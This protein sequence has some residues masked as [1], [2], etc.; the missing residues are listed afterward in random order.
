MSFSNNAIGFYLQVEDSLSPSLVKAEKNYGKF[1]KKLD[2]WNTKAFQS[3]S[4]GFAGVAKAV[5]GGTKGASVG[6]RGGMKIVVDFNKTST[7]ALGMSVA[8]AVA[9]AL[10][11]ATFGSKNAKVA[12]PR[13]SKGGVVGG[14]AGPKVDDQLALLAKGERILS[15]P[16]Y[17]TIEDQ[18][19]QFRNAAGKFSKV[20]AEM[21]NVH[22]VFDSLAASVGDLADASE[23]GLAPEAPAKYAAQMEKLTAVQK[24]FFAQVQA[25]S[26]AMQK[27]LVPV[28]KA[29][30]GQ[31]AALRQNAVKAKAP[32]E[33]LFSKILGP[34]RFLAISAAMKNLGENFQ[35]ISSAAENAAG[36]L[37]LDKAADG[38]I[39]N[40]Q[41]MNTVLGLSPEKLNEFRASFVALGAPLR[42]ALRDLGGMSEATQQL[43]EAGVGKD[44]ALGLTT[45]VYL[46]AKASNVAKDSLADLGSVLAKDLHMSVGDVNASFATLA[47]RA[48]E[49]GMPAQLLVDSMKEVTE[50]N[51]AFFAGMSGAEAKT[52]TDSM[53]AIIASAEKNSKGLGAVMTDVL[54][55]LS[56]PE[57]FKELGAIF[58]GGEAGLKKALTSGDLSTVFSSFSA[59]TAEQ[60]QTASTALKVPL[61]LFSK[62]ATE[63]SALNTS[64]KAMGDVSISAAEA[65]KE[66]ERRA[67]ENM[68]TFQKLTSSMSNAVTNTFPGVIQFFADLNPLTIL[69]TAL[70]LREFG[71]LSL[72]AK[73]KMPTFGKAAAGAATDSIG[74]MLGGKKAAAGAETVLGKVGKIL[75]K[76]LPGTTAFVGVIIT[77][78]ASLWAFLVPLLIAAAPFLLLGAAIALVAGLI[79]YFRNELYALL[80]LGQVFEFWGEIWDALV[81][82]LA[83]GFEWVMEKA[84]A[85]WAFLTGLPATLGAAFSGVHTIITDAFGSAIDWVTAKFTGL[86]S[87]FSDKWEG[88][89]GLFGGSDTP[90]PGAGLTGM[91]RGGFVTGGSGHQIDDVLALLAKGEMVVPAATT[92]RLSE[93]ATNPISSYPMMNRDAVNRVSTPGMSGDSR[94]VEV[95]DAI[96]VVMKSQLEAT[97]SN[98]SVNSYPSRAGGSALGRKMATGDV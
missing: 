21:E 70:L 80:D 47:A 25:A 2:A 89:K 8:R 72:L 65:F 11:K 34:V 85:F 44:L 29:M 79:Y 61:H 58:E 63:G 46:L 37:G 78:T 51:R 84:A 93:Q 53:M 56:D 90:A 31:I 87:W 66:L 48:S 59:M 20:P 18:I 97:R 5:M 32:L 88:F 69:S 42:L 77:A 41:Q 30:N 86:F 57:K 9:S 10:R 68:T 35:G 95:L 27:K 94:A 60:M 50:S 3:A 40:F 67:Y 14:G 38:L 24:I 39:T 73:I 26:P 81:P 55:T 62:L 64:T 82:K 75:T 17:K 98:A 6:G 15:T 76:M 28:L 7:K 12:I 33:G 52:A 71:V 92:A 74:S 4:R 1:V 83:A 91:A 13:F 36:A 96:L 22:K 54:G 19:G 43:V 23:V 45:G 16:D 49:A